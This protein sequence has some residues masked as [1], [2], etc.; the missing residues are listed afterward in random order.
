MPRTSPASRQPA[1]GFTCAN[2]RHSN[3]AP[4]KSALQSCYKAEL[5]ANRLSRI[6]TPP[7]TYLTVSIH[8]GF[9]PP[10]HNGFFAENDLQLK[11]FHDSTPPCT[12]LTVS[13]VILH[14]RCSSVQAFKSRS[15]GGSRQTSLEVY[16]L[17]NLQ[18]TNQ[19]LSRRLRQRRRRRGR[20][21]RLLK[22]I[23]LF[24]IISSLL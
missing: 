10:I 2:R 12:Y 7:C 20:A 6:S 19:Y 8:N 13:T 11:A 14:S 17:L 9:F 18:C 24:C 4:Q 3:L 21:R 1:V 5:V 15:R 22:M 16:L 23:G